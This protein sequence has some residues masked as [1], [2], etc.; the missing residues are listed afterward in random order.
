MANST[1]MRR[2]LDRPYLYL[3]KR[4]WSHLPT[5]LKSYRPV[6]AYGAHLQSLIQLRAERRQ[7]VGTFFFRNRPELQLLVRLLNQ[8]HAGSAV[9][10]A[11]LGCSK[12]A[13]VYS[14]SYALRSARPDLDI[15]LCALDIAPDVLRFGKEGVYSLAHRDMLGFLSLPTFAQDG[16][17]AA[18]TLK[19]QNRSIFERMSS[20]ELEGMFDLEGHQV[21]VKPLFR[22]GITWHLGNA[23]DP[24]LV[25]Q[26]DPQDIVIANRFLCHMNPKEAER[27]LRNIVRLVRP[28]GYLFVTG[29]D[30]SVR[31][32]VARDLAW[33]P[34]TELIGEIHDGDPSL[35][36]DWPWAYWGLEPLDQRREDWQIRYA[37]VFQI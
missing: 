33:K 7:S 4:L 32:N 35:R 24:G 19:D 11:V 16:D 1:F 23:G 14:I 8:N 5:F 12:G 3:S 26:L 34:V 15:R 10:I 2:Y 18:N 17:L 30:L 27:C 9:H 6:R 29:V 37:S 22:E 25:R 13:E 31:T 21:R 36:R 20:E 28:G